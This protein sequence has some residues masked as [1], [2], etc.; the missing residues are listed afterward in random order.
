MRNSFYLSDFQTVIDFMFER[1]HLDSVY[2]FVFNN[3]ILIQQRDKDSEYAL[4]QVRF[5]MDSRVDSKQ[6]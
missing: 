6:C 4:D 2:E 1:T 3:S 5:T